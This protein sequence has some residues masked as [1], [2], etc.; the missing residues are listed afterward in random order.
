MI[1]CSRFLEF[2]AAHRVMQHESKCRTIH[3]HR[4][5]IEVIVTADQLDMVGRV[6]D[7]GVIKGVL[8]QWIDDNLDHT[9]ILRFDDPLLESIS[10]DSESFK[11]PYTV[12][13]NPTAENLSKHIYEI[14][15]QLLKSHGISV[16]KVICWETPNCKADYAEI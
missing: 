10:K 7:F 3:G 11:K 2:D 8:G 9:A 12:M 4:Y 6:I 5:K 14:G 16:V 15:N 13:F 1:T